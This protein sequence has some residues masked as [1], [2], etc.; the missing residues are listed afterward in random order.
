MIHYVPESRK[1]MAASF[2]D[3]VQS[4]VIDAGAALLNTMFSSLGPVMMVSSR[5]ELEGVI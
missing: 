4:R 5:S 1:K 2:S 3:D